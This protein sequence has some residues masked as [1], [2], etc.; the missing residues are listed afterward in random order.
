M[1]CISET[2][3]TAYVE[4]MPYLVAR[5]NLACVHSD[6]DL[7]KV[8]EDNNRSLKKPPLPSAYWRY[9]S[10]APISS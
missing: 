9:T 7:S 3:N 2:A 1:G 10:K 4:R 8:E 6:D 5:P